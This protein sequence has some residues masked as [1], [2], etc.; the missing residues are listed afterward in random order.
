MGIASSAAKKSS[1][2]S[3]RS[4]MSHFTLGLAVPVSCL[5]LAWAAVAG[6]V[7]AGALHGILG[8]SGHR[9]IVEAAVVAGAG[10]AV[11]LIVVVLIGMFARR[12]AKEAGILAATA[13]Y[14]ADEQL[15]TAVAQL[16]DGTE[17]AGPG[18]VMPPPPTRI[19]EFAAVT[20]AL[21]SMQAA[22]VAATVAEARLRT[23]FREVLT[24]LGRRNQSLLYRQLRIIDTLEQQ[25]ASP[26]ALGD[27]FALDHLI[28]RM[29]RHAESLTVLSGAPPARPRTGP[30]PVIDVIRA[31]VAETEDYKR[32]TVRTETDEM[33][34]P[35]AAN[36]MIHL[37]AEL[38]ENATLFSPSST[39]VEVRAERVA[40]G[41]VV[42]VEDRGL[43]IAAD[44]L[45]EM[46]DRLA[47]PPDFDL[48]DADRLGLFVVARLAFRHDAEVSLCP[49]PYR[50][51][52]AVIML[53]DGL[54]LPP[55]TA[56]APGAT[57]EHLRSPG[58]LSL[59]GAV[60]GGSLPA[61]GEDQGVLDRLSGQQPATTF[62]GLPRRVR[63]DS[64]PEPGQD[65]AEPAGAGRGSA[66][67]EAPAPDDAR[68]LAASL[69]RSWQLSRAGEEDEDEGEEV[70]WL[71]MRALGS[72]TS[73]GCSTISPRASRIS[74]GRSSCPVTACSSRRPR[75]C[76]VKTLST[77]RR[78]RPLCRAWP[79]VPVSASRL[80]GC[81]RPSSSSSRV[82]CSSS[83]PGRAAAWRRSARRTRTRARSPTRWRCL[84]SAPNPTWSHTRGS[85]RAR[86]RPS[87]HG[88]ANHWAAKHGAAKHGA[89][90]HGPA[91]QQRS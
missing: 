67:P 33:I 88:A 25:A 66:P 79:P 21:T 87:E 38:I 46:N 62:H 41:F 35:S 18:E 11:A 7:L 58:A 81:G 71:A 39:K 52:K 2:G 45:S 17:T 34:A 83:P 22:S 23:G 12:L 86:H 9:A 53:P 73:P 69:Q 70:L 55:S 85:R 36:D 44:Q 5:V 31:A 10:L 61:S 77:C 90:R 65:P 19:R 40:N 32:V 37:L 47:R 16:R 54:V 63:P 89:A 60:T 43:G 80:A 74:S 91:R 13:R 72:G 56:A 27:L 48:V 42:E 50:G 64:Q 68:R 6:A 75:T 15:P 78:S 28:T 20:T 49:S 84:S 24:S 26:A 57:G 14:L 30:V 59:V 82:C 29:R 1:R 8:K 51:T 76:P 3:G 4:I